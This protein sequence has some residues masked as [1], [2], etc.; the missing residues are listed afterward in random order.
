MTLLVK[1]EEQLLELNLRFHKA[2]GVAGF[3]ITDNNSTDG[4][5]DIIR[6]YQERG[7]VLAVID[8]PGEDY[9]QQQWVDRMVMMAKNVFAADWIINADADEFWWA[10]SGSLVTEVSDERANVLECDVVGMRPLEGI[11]L[12]EWNETTHEVPQRGE[13]DLSPYCIFGSHPHKVMHR[14]AGY[15]R[16]SM[17]NHKV[18]MLPKLQ[19][20]S[21]IEIFHFNLRS[22]EEFL[23]KMIN[24]GEQLARNPRKHGGRHWRYFYALH[25]EGRLEAEYDRVI[26]T[27]CMDALR[28]C[29]GVRTDNRLKDFWKKLEENE[30]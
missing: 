13:M 17:G 22:K 26:G 24:G 25:L 4:T 21:N 8:E 16:I 3:I 29:G 2:M 6:R 11:P 9:R 7:W 30:G 18:K 27:H 20:R 28:A 1:N 5:R 15:L 23:K 14:A 19:R 10:P 12:T